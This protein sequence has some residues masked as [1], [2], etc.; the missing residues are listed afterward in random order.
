MP[1]GWNHDH[2]DWLIGPVGAHRDSDLV[3]QSN[4]AVALARLASIDPEGVDHEEHRFGHFAVGWIDEI[5][6]RPGSA[7]AVLA[8]EICEEV[9]DCPVLDE[10]HLSTLE[11]EAEDEAWPSVACG[12]RFELAGAASVACGPDWRDE[13]GYAVDEVSDDTLYEVLQEQRIE[14]ESTGDG[15][16]RFRRS[17]VADLAHAMA[18]A[19]GLV[20]AFATLVA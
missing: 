12:L 5:A 1:G 9:V 17:D 18:P 10:D 15:W 14:G 20:A 3:A 6:T 19:I 7:C 13:H 16:I 4:Y 8:S 11:C 2:A